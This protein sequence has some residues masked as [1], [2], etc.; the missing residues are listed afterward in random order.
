MVK[1]TLEKLQAEI[2]VKDYLKD[3]VNVEEFLEY[4]KECPCYGRVWSCPPYDFDPVEDYWKKYSSLIVYGYKINFEEEITRA[5]GE[6]ILER[7]KA[8]VSKELFDMEKENPESVSLSAGNCT[9]CGH[10]NCS[11]PEGK[12]CRFARDMRYSIESIGGNVGK[13]AH[14]LLKCELEWVE[15]GKM[16]SHFTLIGGLLK[17]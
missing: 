10:N 13:T 8:I 4:C 14:D 3:Y 12:P 16:P 6:R 9:V 2:S 1:Y 17:K 5:E 11:R 7:V 15:D